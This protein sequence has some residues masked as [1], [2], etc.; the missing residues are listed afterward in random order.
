M[1]EP[2][3]RVAKDDLNSDV[4]REMGRNPKTMISVADTYAVT[5]TNPQKKS[6]NRRKVYHCN[7]RV[8]SLQYLQQVEKW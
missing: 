4:S 7:L 3:A 2:G 8:R 5:L 6:V 1:L